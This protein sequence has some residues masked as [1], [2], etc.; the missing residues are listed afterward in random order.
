MPD[1]PFR[2]IEVLFDKNLYEAPWVSFHPMDNCTSTA[3]KRDGIDKISKLHGGEFR[4]FD[5]DNTKDFWYDKNFPDP[6]STEMQ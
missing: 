4:L 5:F 6:L 1:T 2:K 3:I